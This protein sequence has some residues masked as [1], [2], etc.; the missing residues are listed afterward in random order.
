[1]TISMTTEF[2]YAHYR[3]GEPSCA[4]EES[5]A[6]GEHCGDYF[7]SLHVP[8]HRDLRDPKVRLVPNFPLRF[9]RR[10]FVTGTGNHRSKLAPSRRREE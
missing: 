5:A 9:G 6:S 7:G 8:D 2:E 10:R 1:M 3:L 4:G